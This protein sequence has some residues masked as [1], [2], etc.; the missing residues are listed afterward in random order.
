MYVH[1]CVSI[2]HI[3]IYSSIDGYLGCFLILAIVNNVN[4]IVNNAA[5]SIGVHGVV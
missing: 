2:H 5:I 3:L 1:M 4:N